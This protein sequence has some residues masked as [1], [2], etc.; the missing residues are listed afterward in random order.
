MSTSPLNDSDRGIVPFDLQLYHTNPAVDRN[1]VFGDVEK[2]LRRNSDIFHRCTHA[3]SDS[4]LL[5]QKWS[6]SVQDRC[7]AERPHCVDNKKSKTRFGTL[8]RNPAIS[9]SFLVCVTYIPDLIHVGSGL[10]KL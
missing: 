4:H 9:P 2:P 5:F 6:K 10:G 3:Q 7:M 1:Q 8:G